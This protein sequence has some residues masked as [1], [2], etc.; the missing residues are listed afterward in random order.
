MLRARIGRVALAAAGLVRRL[1]PAAVVAATAAAAAFLRQTDGDMLPCVRPGAANCMCPDPPPS[2]YIENNYAAFRNASGPYFNEPCRQGL[3]LLVSG[4]RCPFA[5]PAIA[6]AVGLG[7]PSFPSPA[8]P[9][10]SA[11]PANGTFGKCELFVNQKRSA[12]VACLGQPRSCMY[13]AQKDG[14][15]V[16]VEA[17]KCAKPEWWSFVPETSL[18][19]Q[20]E[21]AQQLLVAARVQGARGPC[22]VP[23]AWR[24]SRGACASPS[25]PHRCRCPAADCVPEAAPANRY[26]VLCSS[27]AR[28]VVCLQDG[29]TKCSS[30]RLLRRSSPPH[31]C[32]ALSP[33]WGTLS[34]SVLHRKPPH[35]CR[36]HAAPC[37]EAR[38]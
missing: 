14:R 3:V 1:V 7:A 18:D 2:E 38:V 11:G 10:C 25:L 5:V 34:R 21:W 16:W 20:R 28:R 37:A 8:R 27:D 23:L 12:A 30:V 9:P 4:G 13:L 15:D 29:G 33:G 22:I 32:V 6:N 35:C 17:Y 36:P 24:Q 31:A 19:C 26:C